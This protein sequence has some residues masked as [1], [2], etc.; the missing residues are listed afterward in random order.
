MA[1]S[2]HKS[3]NASQKLT[4]CGNLN[5]PGKVRQLMRKIINY[6]LLIINCF[7]ICNVLKKGVPITA[8]IIPN[9]PEQ[10]MLLRECVTR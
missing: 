6:Q 2:I 10:V 1:R 7:Y 9:E 5:T 3:G 8:E 4:A